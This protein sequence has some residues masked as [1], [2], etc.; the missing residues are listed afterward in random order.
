MTQNYL[1]TR[2]PSLAVCGFLLPIN[3]R[4]T[5]VYQIAHLYSDKTWNKDI[6]SPQAREALSDD[7]APHVEG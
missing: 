7:V 2:S 5:V 6:S 3:E 4:L 1:R